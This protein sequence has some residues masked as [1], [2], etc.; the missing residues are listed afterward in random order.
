MASAVL[1]LL[2]RINLHENAA[3][4]LVAATFE[5][6]GLLKDKV[7]I[8]IQNGLLTVSGQVTESTERDEGGY[9]FKERRSGK[10]SRILQLPEATQVNTCD[11]Y[12]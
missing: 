3:S 11:V 12:L 4:N 10:F 6:P 7:N 8:D 2:C 5:L 9:K 1:T